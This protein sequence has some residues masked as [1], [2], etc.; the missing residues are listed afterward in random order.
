VLKKLESG[1]YCRGPPLLIEVVRI[2]NQLIKV[3]LVRKISR[4][5]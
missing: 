5:R 2:K 1:R 4:D 3:K